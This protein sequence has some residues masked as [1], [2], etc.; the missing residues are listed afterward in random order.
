M[1]QKKPVKSIEDNV[2][3]QISSG[4][5][6]MKSRAHFV[7]LNAIL[8]ASASLFAILSAVFVSLSIRDVR[9]GQ[10]LK[11]DEF[12]RQGEA[13]F[14]ATLPWLMVLFGLIAISATLVLV[15]HF[16]F[17][18]RHKT[19]VILATVAFAVLG[20][21]AMTSAS[22]LHDRLA[23]APPFRPLNTFQ[24]Y[25]DEKRIFG[26]IIEIDDYVILV[27]LPTGETIEAKAND[28]WIKGPLLKEG[29]KVVIFGE[30]YEN[31]EKYFK[32]YGI[33]KGDPK[34]R[35]DALEKRLKAE[36]GEIKGLLKR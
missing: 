25:A 30:Y 15:K 10:A 36:I 12:G 26:Q 21:A 9:L 8:I 17:S 31:G 16:E 34:V 23:E 6:Q 11:L 5:V 22:G 4:E 28:T 13:Q 35:R 33:R 27:E 20:I 2:M 32:A 7:V 24:K 18:Y 3:N 1:S 29:D 19:T 14:I